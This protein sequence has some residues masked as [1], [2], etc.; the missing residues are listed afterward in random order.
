MRKL[1]YND[2]K[3]REATTSNDKNS[4]MITTLERSLADFVQKLIDLEKENTRYE[5]LH[6]RRDATRQSY[7]IPSAKKT[8]RAKPYNR[9]RFSALRDSIAETDRG[10]STPR[11]SDGAEVE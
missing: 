1:A 11:V 2:W 4:D 5:N 8:Q 7:S 9:P 3:L 10:I 6:K